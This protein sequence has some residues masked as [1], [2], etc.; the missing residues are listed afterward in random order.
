MRN[1]EYSNLHREYNAQ[2]VEYNELI[3]KIIKLKFDMSKLWNYKNEYPQSWKDCAEKLTAN[4]KTAADLK[5]SIKETKTK[6]RKS[7]SKYI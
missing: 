6:M 5:C 7:N 2:V 1:Q 4:R 3:E